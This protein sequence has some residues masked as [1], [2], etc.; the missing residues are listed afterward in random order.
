MPITNNVVWDE[1]LATF[2]G[3][4]TPNFVALVTAA[5]T[6]CAAC[7]LALR[8]DER[9]AMS[10]DIA[11]GRDVE[12]VEFITFSSRVSHLR[13]REPAFTL[14]KAVGTPGELGT[15]GARFTLEQ[16]QGAGTRT[17]PALVC[18]LIPVMSFREPGG[19]LTS[20]VVSVLLA[21]GFQL[22][23][24][25]DYGEIIQEARDVTSGVCCLLTGR[26]V[27][28]LRIGGDQIYSLL[29]DP[30]DA[31]DVQWLEAATREGK[32]LVL[33]G[34][35]LEITDTGL[36]VDAAARLGTLATGNVPFLL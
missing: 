1:R 4:D 8:P 24:T 5:A 10:V 14:R 12:G 25:A 3:R 32:V 31:A 34:D 33:S 22:S 28:S 30:A 36:N 19:E 23:M 20:A 26:G 11:E 16:R 2:K 18:T 17:V 15:R 6:F 13:C 29:L 21:H 9:L 27:L 35:Y 7:G